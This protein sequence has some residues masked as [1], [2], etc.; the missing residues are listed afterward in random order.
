MCSVY[1]CKEILAYILKMLLKILSFVMNI[2]P[3]KN[4]K[5]RPAAL[6]TRAAD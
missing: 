5:S 3:L 2:C 1:L 4:K 6:F